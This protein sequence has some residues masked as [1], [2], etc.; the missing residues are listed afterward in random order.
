MLQCAALALAGGKH[1]E[2]G[3]YLEHMKSSKLTYNVQKLVQLA[4]LGIPAAPLPKTKWVEACEAARKAGLICPP[5]H[6]NHAGLELSKKWAPG[7][8]IA[9]WSNEWCL[10]SLGAWWFRLASVMDLQNHQRAVCKIAVD[11]GYR[12]GEEAEKVAMQYD[13]LVRRKLWDKYRQSPST[14]LVARYFA[15]EVE[16]IIAEAERIVRA[17][18]ADNTGAGAA[19]SDG[20]KRFCMKHA[21]GKPCSGPP[22]CQ[23]QHACAFYQGCT[24][25]GCLLTHLANQGQGKSGGK[26]KPAK[27]GHR[28]EDHVR[29]SD[30]RDED[31]KDEH[32][33][34]RSRGRDRRR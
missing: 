30:R 21:L 26:G 5:Y 28:R 31:V 27:D 10:Y 6:E 23:M 32:S 17:D 9:E 25:H 2:L 20:A 8:T 15:G 18:T 11:R 1:E 24:G 13:H 34:S 22:R 7:K 33:R 29:Q 19:A 14:L 12:S 16:G 3:D 4:Q